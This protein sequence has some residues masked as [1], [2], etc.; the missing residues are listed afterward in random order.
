[1][2]RLLVQDVACTQLESGVDLLHLLVD[3][4]VKQPIGGNKAGELGRTFEL[5]ALYPFE[6]G[7]EAQV[8]NGLF[9]ECN[10]NIPATKADWCDNNDL[11]REGWPYDLALDFSWP[12]T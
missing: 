2:Q 5:K 1:M 7:V 12:S 9:A 11:D 3:L 6:V 4:T 8:P 10:G